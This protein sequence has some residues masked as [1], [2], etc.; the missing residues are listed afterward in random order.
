MN[1]T[2]CG[3]AFSYKSCLIKH[4]KHKEICRFINVE[5]PSTES[6]S[7]LRISETLLIWSLQMSSFIPQTSL[8]ICGLLANRNIILLEQTLA[9]CA[10]SRESRNFARG[11]KNLV[12]AVNVM[13]PSLVNQVTFYVSKEP[14]GRKLR[15]IQGRK[16]VNKNSRSLYS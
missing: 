10:P 16:T 6:Y 1:Y 13:V 8:N 11:N 3:K 9:R 15:Y 4:K 2:G 7:F 5:N 12:T 14:M